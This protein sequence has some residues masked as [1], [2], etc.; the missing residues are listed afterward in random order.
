MQMHIRPSDLALV[1]VSLVALLFVFTL[2]SAARSDAGDAWSVNRALVN[3]LGLT[4]LCLVTEA[5]YTRHLS[6]ADH[7]APFQ[8]HP[9]ALEH[10]PS[11]AILSPPP[12]LT[13]HAPLAR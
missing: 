8:D 2:V 11:G 5:R 1:G 4:D 12:H 7:H 13:S 10:F 3:A 6:L 9:M